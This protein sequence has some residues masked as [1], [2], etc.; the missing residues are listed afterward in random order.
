MIEP[1]FKYLRTVRVNHFLWQ[2]KSLGS[3]SGDCF[4]LFPGFGQSLDE[5]NFLENELIKT[6]N[7]IIALGL[8]YHDSKLYSEQK[9]KI[10]SRADLDNCISKICE[11]EGIRSFQLIG[12]SM[13]SRIALNL[14]DSDLK[15]QIRGLYL[16]A[17]DGFHENHWYRFLIS[18]AGRAFFKWVINFPVL[19]N[20]TFR[21]I[22]RT[23]LIGKTE[24]KIMS[25]AL[26]REDIPHLVYNT[27]NTYRRLKVNQNAMNQLSD[28]KRKKFIFGK[29]DRIISIK[30]IKRLHKMGVPY[31]EIDMWSC[32]HEIIVPQNMKRIMELIEGKDRL[33]ES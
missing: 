3:V 6:G 22:Q 9:Q 23:R 4:I 11:I 28:L 30:S 15:S 26:S 7:R 16:F 13:G 14:L 12:Y 8:L 27:W 19:I 25:Y 17:P 2:Y 18:A 24:E 31:I 33:S 29:Y 32:G 21:V 20:N 10:V 5:F 1:S